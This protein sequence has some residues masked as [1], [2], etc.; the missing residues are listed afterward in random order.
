MPGAV[1]DGTLMVRLRFTLLLNASWTVDMLRVPVG[2]PACEARVRVTLP[3]N[4]FRLSKFSTIVEF[5][6]DGRLAE[7]GVAVKLK[8]VAARV[9]RIWWERVPSLAVTVIR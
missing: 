7:F 9:R 1:F 2:P 6:P 8:S 3:W 5:E 4:K